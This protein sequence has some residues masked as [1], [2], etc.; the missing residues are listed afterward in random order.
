MRAQ[1]ASLTMLASACVW[2]MSTSSVLLAWRSSSDSPMQKMTL[3][4]RSNARLVF[5]ATTSSFS[6]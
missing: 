1:S 2:R 5:L 3:R 6:L 4:P